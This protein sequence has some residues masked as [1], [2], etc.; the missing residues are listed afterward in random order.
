VVS[1][2]R[3][4]H[5]IA[6][7]GGGGAE[8][9]C[10]YLATELVRRGW[11]VDVALWAG[12]PNLERLEAG[13]A[14]IHWLKGFNQW[15]PRLAWQLL[16][17]V[18]KTRPDL[19]Q[20]WTA[21]MDVP[22][23]IACRTLSVPWLVCE[24]GLGAWNPMSFGHVRCRLR[25]LVASGA[26][27]VVCNSASA[28]RTWEPYLPGKTPRYIIRNV[29]PI[30]E[31]QQTSPAPTPQTQAATRPKTVLAVGRFVSYK[32]W[33]VLIEAMAHVARRIPVTALFCG[34]GPWRGQMENMIGQ[35]GL[36]DVIDLPGYVDDVW[37]RMKGADVSVNISRFE[38]CPNVVIEAMA[39]GCPLV[40]S[41]IP[42]HRE[43]LDDDMALIVD[44][45]DPV[46]VADAIVRA[47]GDPE[48][49]RQRATRARARAEQWTGA[50]IARKYA[51]LYSDILTRRRL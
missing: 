13:G 48:R 30:S 41:D 7:M 38:G 24:R 25:L 18:G 46:Q 35:L 20:T 3:V 11:Q 6:T 34:V 23:G 31:I 4:P 36:T 40:V 51:N 15:D 1:S 16:R 50:S 14:R 29:L 42:P 26:S 47:L 49:A 10:A 32:N 33:Q 43:V 22:G 12:G 21:V 17:I 28:A 39:C 9:Q 44:H 8:R 37:A 5:C 27:A 45:T 2:G 19:V